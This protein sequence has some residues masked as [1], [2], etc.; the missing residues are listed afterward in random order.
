M[1]KLDQCG[2]L[3]EAGRAP[4]APEVEQHNLAAVAGKVDGGGAIG[5]GE[6]RRRLTRLRRMRTTVAAGR[7]GQG[8]EDEKKQKPGEPHILIIRSERAL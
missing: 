2:K 8:K 1:V 3:R 7:Q 6:V 5:E 4:G